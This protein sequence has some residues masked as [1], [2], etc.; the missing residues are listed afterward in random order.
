M[1]GNLP[2]FQIGSALYRPRPMFLISNLEA[3]AC[4]QYVI[5]LAHNTR[6]FDPPTALEGAKSSVPEV[7]LHTRWPDLHRLILE[8]RR[9]AKKVDRP[10]CCYPVQ[11]SSLLLQSIHTQTPLLRSVRTRRFPISFVAR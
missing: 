4:R 11:K 1:S 7:R 10:A 3:C 6:S 5:G 2:L 8:L 9:V